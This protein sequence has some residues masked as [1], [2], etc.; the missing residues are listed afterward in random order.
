MKDPGPKQVI[1]LA[2]EVGGLDEDLEI[3]KH[4]KLKFVH[5]KFLHFGVNVCL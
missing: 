5:E 2:V 4:G 3:I 1:V